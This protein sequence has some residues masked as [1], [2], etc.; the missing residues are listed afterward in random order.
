MELEREPGGEEERGRERGWGSEG[1][2]DQER[3]REGGE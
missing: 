1:E 2:R 3:E